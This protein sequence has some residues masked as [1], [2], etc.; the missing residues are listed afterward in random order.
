M[1]I[2][3]NLA[4]K[5]YLNRQG[6]RLWL[7]LACSF[8]LL[9]LVINGYYGYQNFRQLR[10]LESRF[11]ELDGQAFT[12]QGAPSG[13]TPE[14][15]AAVGDKIVLANAIVAADQF[16]WTVLL[17]RFEE[18]VPDD[19]SI[20]T[21]QPNFKERSVTLAGV[22]L[23]VSAMTRFVD[24]LLL[25]ED[26]NQAYLQRHGEVKSDQGGGNQFYVG[27]SLVIREAF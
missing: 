26:L 8:M 4:S 1:E 14:N 17:S 19:V 7:L 25:S 24:N 11:L 12:V 27:F 22:A 6:V 2:K 9:L 20:R 3:L 16:R 5:P 10:L 18:L 21:I 23:D 13:Y 15:Y